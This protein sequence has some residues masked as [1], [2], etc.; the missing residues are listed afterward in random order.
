VA[1][2]FAPRR[3]AISARLFLFLLSFAGMYPCSQSDFVVC[4]SFFFFCFSFFL[5]HFLWRTLFDFLSHRR[6]VPSNLQRPPLL[7]VA[8]F[9]SISALKSTDLP[10]SES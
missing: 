1:A 2:G 9:H 3:L 10:P 6:A 5:F 8:S 7:R 4:L